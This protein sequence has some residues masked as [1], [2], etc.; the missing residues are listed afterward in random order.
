MTEGWGR[1][2]AGCRGRVGSRPESRVEGSPTQRYQ[3]CGCHCIHPSASEKGKSGTGGG[4]ERGG[5][6]KRGGGEREGEGRGK[7]RG[8]GRGRVEIKLLPLN[9]TNPVAVIAFTLQLQRKVS[10]GPVG[11]RGGGEWEGKGK[12]KGGEKEGRGRGRGKG[13][14]RG[15]VG[16]NQT[17]AGVTHLICVDNLTQLSQNSS[18]WRRRSLVLPC[19][20]AQP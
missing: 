7:G 5:R 14:E 3:P 16:D 19:R 10:L 8:E 9:D 2:G 6:R 4:G 13:G 20:L 12:G 1:G 17:V 15:G 11:E 18:P